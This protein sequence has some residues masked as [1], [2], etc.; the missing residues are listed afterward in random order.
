MRPLILLLVL[1]GCTKPDT[2]PMRPVL[3]MN[4]EGAELVERASQVLN[5]ADIECEFRPV[6]EI[7]PEQ[8]PEWAADA[9]SG[10][11]LYV[12]EDQA[13]R[14]KAEYDAWITA[15]AARATPEPA[16]PFVLGPA[17]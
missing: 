14:A 13:E 3:L 4:T 15:M 10:W 12:R 17:L 2:R 11:L 16:E 1:F 6:A 7:A 9:E 8:R 5:R